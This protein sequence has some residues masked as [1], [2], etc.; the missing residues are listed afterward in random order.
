MIINRRTMLAG[1]TAAAAGIGGRSQ[2]CQAADE[3]IPNTPADD[4]AMPAPEEST[5]SVPQPGLPTLGGRQFWGDVAFRAGFR[6]QRNV[7]T[8]HFRLLDASD[9]RYASGTEAECR[10]ALEAIV[11]D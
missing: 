4:P 6:I 2:N 7:F 3:A 1:L 8:G 10:S 5:D 9:R 11:R